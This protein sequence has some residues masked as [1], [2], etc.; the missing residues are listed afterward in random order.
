MFKSML[1]MVHSI[2]KKLDGITSNEKNTLEQRDQSTR[3][4]EKDLNI[5]F[6]LIRCN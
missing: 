3:R 6:R 1:F 2:H 5:S 4:T